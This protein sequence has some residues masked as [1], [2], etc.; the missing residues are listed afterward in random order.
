MRSGVLI[1]LIFVL[2]GCNMNI[3][4]VYFDSKSSLLYIDSVDNPDYVI[5]SATIYSEAGVES[6]FYDANDSL[7]LRQYSFK[8]YLDSINKHQF[9]VSVYLRRTTDSYIFYYGEIEDDSTTVEIKQS[10]L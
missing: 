5:S 3:P 7:R 4:H 8:S 1:A 10:D 9:S 2:A 6:E